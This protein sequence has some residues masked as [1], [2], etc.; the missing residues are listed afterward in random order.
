MRRVAIALLFSACTFGPREVPLLDVH[1]VGPQRLDPGAELRI[2]G[3]GFPLAREGTARCRGQFYSPAQVART[4]DVSLPV[5]VRAAELAVAIVDEQHIERFGGRGTFLGELTLSFD[6]PDGSR[7]IGS[8]TAELD[9]A[10]ATRTTLRHRRSELEHA[11]Q[12]SAQLG[13]EFLQD[14]S[15]VRVLSVQDDG[16]ATE[17]GIRA[18]DRVAHLDHVR[19][20]SLRDLRSASAQPQLVLSRQGRRAPLIFQLPLSPSA[21][22]A[23]LDLSS[24]VLLALLLL[25][26]LGLGPLRSLADHG[27]V[28]CRWHAIR[29]AHRPLLPLVFGLGVGASLLPIAALVGL[30]AVSLTMVGK[31]GLSG[32]LSLAF[33]V[34]WWWWCGAE[35]LATQLMVWP[36]VFASLAWPAELP[37]RP[38][39]A[40][41][42]L[43]L[44]CALLAAVMWSDSVWIAPTAAVMFTGSWV[45][46]PAGPWSRA[47]AL[48]GVGTLVVS[49]V[50]PSDWLD[51]SISTDAAHLLAM[52]LTAVVAISSLLSTK[53]R[54]IR[55]KLFL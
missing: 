39:L 31:W 37:P 19:V 25:I 11:R 20:R 44:E 18:G 14:A 33:C 5:R 55:D 27:W 53:S 17:A 28:R 48:V 24:L 32:R 46:P 7:V 16:W 41:F 1:S 4:V 9:L 42:V 6:A 54:P 3:A 30:L 38:L 8:T 47:V 49:T 23:E 10:P 15:G 12:L 40:Q 43:A 21:M 50:W 35:P 22:R 36:L 45:L 52:A 26:S 13:L 2:V 29:R 51:L 34:A